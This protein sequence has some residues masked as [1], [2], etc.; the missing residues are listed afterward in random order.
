MEPINIDVKQII[1]I[2]VDHASER[3]KHEKNNIFN[4]ITNSIILGN[5]ANNKVTDKIEPS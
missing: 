5:A 3:K 1:N 2:I 4:I